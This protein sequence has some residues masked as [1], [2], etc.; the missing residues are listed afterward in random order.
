MASTLRT[1]LDSPELP[2][3]NGVSI[4]GNGWGYSE[5]ANTLFH[6]ILHCVCG[7]MC[8]HM[9]IC[10]LVLWYLWRSENNLWESVL[11]FYHVGPRIELRSSDKAA[12]IR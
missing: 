9:R 12:V 5:S 3:K 1:V 11:S 2:D 4:V 10:I 8:L 7:C 6:L